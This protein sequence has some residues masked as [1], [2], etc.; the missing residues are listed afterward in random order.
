MYMA[1]HSDVPFAFL[2]F[3]RKP[4]LHFSQQ[5]LCITA[6]TGLPRLLVDIRHEASH[7][8]LPSLSLLRL[9]AAEAVQWLQAAYWQRQQ[10]HLHQQQQ[11]VVELLKVPRLSCIIRLTLAGQNPCIH[12]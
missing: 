1:S 7:N 12:L 5:C 8:D 10:A 11:R 2:L 9:A 3:V 4:S 6:V